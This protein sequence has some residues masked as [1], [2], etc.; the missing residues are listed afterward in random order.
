[1]PV[2][3]MVAAEA[4]DALGWDIFFL[5][6]PAFNMTTEQ[7]RIETVKEAPNIV[8]LMAD[9]H[10]YRYAKQYISP[11]RKELPRSL[12][13]ASTDLNPNDLM[14]WQ[15]DL[16][17]AIRGVPTEPLQALAA[18]TQSRNFDGIPQVVLD[19]P[20]SLPEY[21]PATT[22]FEQY[23]RLRGGRF[24]DIPTTLFG[25][26]VK[27]EDVVHRVVLLRLKYATQGFNLLGD[28]KDS[29][30]ALSMFR[31][32][33]DKELVGQP[34]NL[35]WTCTVP[36]PMDLT[37]ALIR[38]LAD[39]GVKLLTFEWR[40]GIQNQIDHVIDTSSRAGVQPMVRLMFGG[41]KPWEY[42][43]MAKLLEANVNIA[44]QPRLLEHD[45]SMGDEAYV[46]SLTNGLY[47]TESSNLHADMTL[48]AV[49]QLVLNKD[50]KR[51]ERWAEHESK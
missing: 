48:L 15:P 25:Q 26:Q 46:S 37:T 27:V 49:T 35:A 32:L 47:L 30:W 6:T 10:Q 4:L 28:V 8:I 5:D 41:R 45:A 39:H 11:V 43:E 21:H 16:D 1:M 33:E 22:N 9:R 42:V 44:L 36:N 51:L 34:A 23:A 12:L 38:E 18:R 3:G 20:V 2:E 19:K 13:V 7:V 31:R 50:V 40:P 29:N 24:A 14:R 17:F